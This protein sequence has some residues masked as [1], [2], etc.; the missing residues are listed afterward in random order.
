MP[1]TH[2]P[3][4]NQ[5]SALAVAI[6]ITNGQVSFS[7]DPNIVLPN[8]NLDLTGLPGGVQIFMVIET[9]GWCFYNDGTDSAAEALFL[10]ANQPDKT[11]STPLPSVFKDAALNPPFFNVLTLT[12]KNNDH[13]RYY[14]TLNFI[15]SQSNPLSWDPIIFNN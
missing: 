5:D 4:G 11:R 1:R 10:A 12:S 8:G 14:Y 7:G 15:D 13:K 9:A 6:T 3:P 2:T